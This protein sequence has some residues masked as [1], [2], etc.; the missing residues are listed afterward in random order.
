[1]SRYHVAAGADATPA[2]QRLAGD[3]SRAFSLLDANSKARRFAKAALPTD[4][5]VRV[6]IVTDDVGGEVLAFFT[7]AG[8]WRRSTDRALVS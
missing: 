7:S 3:V 4:D 1:M 6:A 5:S 8:E 2:V